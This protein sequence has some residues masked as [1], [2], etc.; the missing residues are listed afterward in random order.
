MQEEQAMVSTGRQLD[1]ARFLLRLWTE[2][3]KV[4]EVWEERRKNQ[5]RM[6][7]YEELCVSL[8]VVKDQTP[9]RFSLVWRSVVLGHVDWDV[10]A[11]GIL[12]LS[13]SSLKEVNATL[14]YMA[15]DLMPDP[16]RVPAHLRPERVNRA[17]KTSLWRG[18]TPAHRKARRERDEEIVKQRA[19]GWKVARIARFHSIDERRVKQILSERRKS[20]SVLGPGQGAA[21]GI[22]EIV[23]AQGD[24]EDRRDRRQSEVKGLERASTSSSSNAHGWESTTDGASGGRLRVQR[25]E[26]QVASQVGWSEPFDGRA[27]KAMANLQA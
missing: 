6:G 22:E 27:E 20:D 19:Q 24:G 13:E 16:I 2:P 1:R 18:R 23:P 15:Y 12:R 8:G 10:P 17:R 5:W 4:E 25:P 14:Y 7:S 11:R 9:M 26:T 21:G 3:E